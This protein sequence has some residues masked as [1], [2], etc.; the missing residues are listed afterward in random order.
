[1]KIIERIELKYFRS[2]GEKNVKITDLKDLNIFS[3][4]N[5]V[6]KSNVLR[7]LNLFFNDEINIGEKFDL[8]KDLSFLQRNR[9]QRMLESKRDTRTKNDPFASQRDLFVKVKIFF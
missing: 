1:M 8:K 9:S 4:S 6:G 3:G 2:F 7:A 5:D